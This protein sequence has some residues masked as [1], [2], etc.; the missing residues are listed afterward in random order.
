MKRILFLCAFCVSMFSVA[1][2]D[3]EVLKKIY[4]NSLTNGQSYQWLNYLS[5]QIGGRLSGSLN[6]ER[7]VQWTKEE[8]EKVGPTIIVG[9]LVKRAMKSARSSVKTSSVI[10][11]VLFADEPC[12]RLVMATT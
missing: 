5:N 11:P 7:A 3:A 12:S 1:Q 8:L 2:S 6:A 10:V 4:D 9:A